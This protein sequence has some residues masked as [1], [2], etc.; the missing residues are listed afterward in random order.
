MKIFLKTCFT[1]VMAIVV[2]GCVTNSADVGTTRLD[3]V[4]EATKTLYQSYRM[5]LKKNSNVSGAFAYDEVLKAS[6]WATRS[7]VDG[8]SASS[9]AALKSCK[10]YGGSNCKILD[11]NGRIVWKGVSAS[12]Y[13]QLT[14]PTS[15]ST[16]S[17]IYKF[18]NN[19]FDLSDKQKRGYT[20]Y[21]KHSVSQNFSVFF[22][23][24]DRKSTSSGFS[25]GTY[26]TAVL[27]SALN[28]CK[29]KS[30]SSRCYL[31][32]ENGKPI[33]SS[34][35]MAIANVSGKP[36][37]TSSDGN[38]TISTKLKKLKEFL[39]EGVITQNDYNKKKEEL[40]SK[41]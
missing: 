38:D 10:K 5:T 8:R 41:L 3:D 21:I 23:S 40:L 17:T 1:G 25:D 16:D 29:I 13:N 20:S 11:Q 36:A 30:N 15:V 2:S 12:L 35:A 14:K 31:F 18:E 26:S 4:S 9:A 22:V 6:A 28:S 34:A 37:K 27:T 24:E 19:L 32:A 7:G 39:D 33:N